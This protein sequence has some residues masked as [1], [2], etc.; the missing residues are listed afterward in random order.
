MRWFHTLE[1]STASSI[2]LAAN[3]E[4]DGYKVVRSEGRPVVMQV[5]GDVKYG[6]ND[7]AELAMSVW[8]S[9]PDR[10]RDEYVGVVIDEGNGLAEGVA[11]GAAEAEEEE[12]EAE[13]DAVVEDEADEAEGPPE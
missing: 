5:S 4:A 3:A 9:V 10:L 2:E 13:P 6:F 1:T 12:E 11:L 7:K 8:L